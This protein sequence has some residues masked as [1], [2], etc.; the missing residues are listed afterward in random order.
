[1]SLVAELQNMWNKKILRGKKIIEKSIIFS[2]SERPSK[3]Q[4]WKGV[5][6]LNTIIQT[7]KICIN[8]KKVFE[9]CLNT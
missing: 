4:I 6:D 5:V 9:K 8:N 1:M 2:I 3:Q 7:L